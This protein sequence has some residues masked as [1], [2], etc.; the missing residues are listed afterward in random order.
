MH[1]VVYAIALEVFVCPAGALSPSQPAQEMAE[2][3]TRVE[4]VEDA[5]LPVNVELLTVRVLDCCELLLAA[6]D[7][8]SR[9]S[10]KGRPWERNRAGWR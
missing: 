6:R 5:W 4:D 8:P 1:E 2:G 3:F 7:V 9:P 10:L